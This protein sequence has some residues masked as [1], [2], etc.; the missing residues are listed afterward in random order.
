MKIINSIAIALM[1]LVAQIS[2]KPKNFTTPG[3]GSGN[4]TEHIQTAANFDSAGAK[5]EVCPTGDCQNGKFSTAVTGKKATATGRK[6]KPRSLATLHPYGKH[7]P[8]QLDHHFAGI[9]NGLGLLVKLEAKGP[10]G[11]GLPTKKAKGSDAKAKKLDRVDFGDPMF[12]DAPTFALIDDTSVETALLNSSVV[13]IQGGVAF[14]WVF[15]HFTKKLH[16][17]PVLGEDSTA[18]GSGS[19]SLSGNTTTETTGSSSAS[20]LSLSCYAVVGVTALVFGL[21]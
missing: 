18:S 16:Y 1:C 10:K 7:S 21:F 11:K 2:G 12:M 3:H 17:D 15:P 19:P 8:S 6:S 4:D 13:E 5:M 20:K 9:D 14:R